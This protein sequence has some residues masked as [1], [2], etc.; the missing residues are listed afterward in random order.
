MYEFQIEFLEPVDPKV[1]KSPVSSCV[2]GK[3]LPQVTSFG[4]L[5]ASRFLICDM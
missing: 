4:D 3:R 1:R 2:F 5:D